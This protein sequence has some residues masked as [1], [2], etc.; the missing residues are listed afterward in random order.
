M[1][2]IFSPRIRALDSN[3]DPISGAT[4]RINLSG[5]STLASVYSDA[6]LT[7]PL[8]NPVVADSAGWLPQIYATEGLIVDFVPSPGWTFSGEGIT[9]LG[10]STSTF[11]RDFTGSRVQM[12][13]SAGV[14]QIETGPATG[15]DTG[16]SGRIGGWDATQGEALGLDY[17]AVNVTGRLTEKDKKLTGTVYTEATFSGSLSVV[18]PLTADP[19]GVRTWD[20]DVT[21]LKFLLPSASDGLYCQ[22]SIDGGA[23]YAAGTSYT[24][25]AINQPE[26]VLA[27]GTQTSSNGAGRLTLRVAA[28]AAS[29]TTGTLIYGT[30]VTHSSSQVYAQNVG[31]LYTG[32]T[33]PTHI[34][35]YVKVAGNSIQGRYRLVPVRGLGE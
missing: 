17:A 10:G 7:V 3:A 28:S 6:A 30:C 26:I 22:V 32:T 21:D 13:D 27:N 9:A 5:T 29:A 15:D 12:R 24:T 19:T 33:I 34:K 25:T 20:I 4:L 23:T 1:A 11:S 8:T 14:V 16:G 18:I 2:V 31:G 35:L